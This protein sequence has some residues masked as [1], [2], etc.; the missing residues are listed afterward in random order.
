M[1]IPTA[2]PNL[3]KQFRVEAGRAEDDTALD[4]VLNNNYDAA[5]GVLDGLSLTGINA[6][7]RALALRLMTA[8]LTQITPAG[9]GVSEQAG[10]MS[11]RRLTEGK[12]T[13]WL[14]TTAGDTANALLGGA[15]GGLTVSGHAVAQP[16]SNE[17]TYA[18]SN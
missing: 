17:P 18:T 6:E 15:L 9:A 8:H 10:P 3:I 2:D 16:T 13:G 7:R 12:G 4:I 1:P 14:A 5:V 11:I